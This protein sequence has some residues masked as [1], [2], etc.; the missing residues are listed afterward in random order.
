[1][2]FGKTVPYMYVDIDK[3]V[4]ILRSGGVVA[5]PT[6][7]VYGLAGSIDIETSLKKIFT[8]KGR[9]LFDPLIVHIS[10]LGMLSDL[11]IQPDPILLKLAKKFWP[12]PLTIIFKRNPKK[13]SDLITAGH[14][15]VA[16]R[17]PKHSQTEKIITELN[18]AIAAPSANP[19]KK[20]SPSEAKHVHDYFPD[21]D[22]V[23]GGPCDVGLES[24]IVRLNHN[25]LE[26][27][28]PGK[29]TIE[30]L[31]NFIKSLKL[32]VKLSIKES[33]NLEGPG[34]MKEHYQP[35]SPLYLFKNKDIDLT[36]PD[37]KDINVLTLNFPNDPFLFARVLYKT[38]IET[39]KK[40]DALAYSWTHNENDPNWTAI[41]NRLEKA[42]KVIL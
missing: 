32:D 13:I 10:S 14:E 27:L 9:P 11:V 12:G 2:N 23:N 26:L 30:D 29:I 28:R 25:T 1:M 21:L 18:C 3:A 34:S 36:H 37:F 19:F 20:T 17:W 42:S 6:E 7:T 39:S 4:D 24:T 31:Q 38:L 16:V 22:I 35:E 5:V 40:S 33:Y 15:T 41:Y 8:T